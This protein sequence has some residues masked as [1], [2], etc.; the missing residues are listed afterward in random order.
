MKRLYAACG[1]LLL[2]LG[3]SLTNGWYARRLTART[4]EELERARALAAQENWDGA[5]EVTEEAFRRWQNNSLYLHIVMRH[6]DADQI[7]RAF[8]QVG[9]LLSDRDWGQYAAANTDL[10]VQ[11]GLL[12]DKETATL[13]NVL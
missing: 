4:A 1:I 6:E 10:I 12:S 11:L 5:A 7:L 9:Q 8:R 2:L 13:D 3:L